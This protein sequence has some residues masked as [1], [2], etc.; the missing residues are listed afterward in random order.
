M[1]AT[2]HN[3]L[4]LSMFTDLSSP[5]TC[6]DGDVRLVNSTRANAGRV[7]VCH[8]NHYGTVCEDDWSTEDANVV[9]GQLGF[10]KFGN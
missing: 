9:C 8:D 6:V 5:T 2:L 7:E 3:E 4:V 10:E 1:F